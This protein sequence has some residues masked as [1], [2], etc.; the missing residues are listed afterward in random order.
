[1]AELGYTPD[2]NQ[3]EESFEIVPAGEYICIIAES[4][5]APNK[6]NTGMILKLTW[7][8]IDG[9]LKERK[10][11]ENLNLQHENAQAAV[12]GQKALNSICIAAGIQHVQDSAQLHGIPMI[13]DISVK[14]DPTYGKQ[15]QIKKH[16]PY[17]KS[18]SVPGATPPPAAGGFQQPVAPATGTAGV[19]KQPWQ[20]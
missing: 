10:I 4:D 13:L 3:P 17:Q 12:I 15:N 19:K 7:E 14:D 9:P 18:N 5:Y 2:Y 8:V 20:Q 6:K 11:F 1:M 16:L